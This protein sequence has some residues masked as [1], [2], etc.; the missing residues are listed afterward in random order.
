M[1][2]LKNVSVQMYCKSFVFKQ[3]QISIKKSDRL[4]SCEEKKLIISNKKVQQ[5]GKKKDR[6]C[7]QKSSL[8]DS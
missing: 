6:K 5:N 8:I 7:R 1:K 4:Q 3:L 2:L